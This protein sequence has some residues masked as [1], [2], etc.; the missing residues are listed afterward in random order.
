MVTHQVITELKVVVYEGTYDECLKYK[1]KHKETVL[2]IVPVF[3]E[4]D[5]KNEVLKL[6]K[7]L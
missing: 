4:T 2:T 3:T 5:F 7:L 1:S 6:V